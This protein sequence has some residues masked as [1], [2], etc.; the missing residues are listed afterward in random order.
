MNDARHPDDA[1]LERRLRGSRTLDEAPE[2]LIQRAIGVWRPRAA[3]SA[4]GALRRLAATLRFDSRL[5]DA[6][7]LGLR[8]ADGATDGATRQLLFSADGR[9]IDLRLEPQTGGRWSVS[10]Q[11]LGPDE[12][13]GA[14][15]LPE[16]APPQQVAWNELAEF[17]FEPVVAVRATL[18]LRGSDWEVELPLEF[19]GGAG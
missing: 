19:A 18:R 12:Q 4:A 7:A 2:P 15:L 17:I 9:D 6:T 13:G 10:G 14:E 8:A 3:A 5:A 1:E 16:G 11:V